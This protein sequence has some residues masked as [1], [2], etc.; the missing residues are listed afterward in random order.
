MDATMTR[1]LRK[2]MAV[3]IAADG[4]MVVMNRPEFSTTETGGYVKGNY[5]PL[6]PQLFRLVPYRRRLTDLTTPQADG[7]IPTIPYTLVGLHNSNIQRMDEFELDGVFY[8]VQGLE[9]HTNDRVHTDRV[10]A[11][12]IALDAAGVSWSGP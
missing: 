9:P 12:L 1:Y 5:V 6:P 4:R 11:Q 2:V 10:V 7:E 3:F 8:R